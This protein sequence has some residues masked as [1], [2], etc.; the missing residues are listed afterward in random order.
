MNSLAC[1]IDLLCPFVAPLL[2]LARFRPKLVALWS[3]LGENAGGRATQTGCRDQIDWRGY[4][5]TLKVAL[6]PWSVL[7]LHTVTLSFAWY[8]T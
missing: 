2:S 5:A 1:R 4:L 3:L 8:C 7:H 6:L